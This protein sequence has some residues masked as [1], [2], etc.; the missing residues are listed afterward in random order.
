MRILSTFCLFIV[1]LSA[2]AAQVTFQQ[3]PGL[4]FFDDQGY[5]NGVSWVDVDNDDDLDVCVTGS[6][7]TFPNFT[8]I[9]AIFLNN[10][11]E[12]FTNTGLLN[13]VQKNA[14]R[15]G[16]ADYD[17]DDDLDLYIGATWNSNGINELWNNNGG[18]SLTLT[19]N[20]GATPNVAQPYEG[21]VSWADYDNDGWADL[22]VP[23]WNDLKNKLYRNNGNGSF[24]EITTGAMVNDLGWTSGGFWGDFDN[25]RDLDLFVVNYQIGP[26][27]PG[28]NHLF[29]NNGN[30]TFTKMTNAGPAVTIAQ[31]GRSANWVDANNDGLLDLFVCNQF[32]QD[33]LHINAGNGT[34][35]T[36]FIGATNHTSWSSNWGD[37]DNDGD[38]DLITIGFWN[39]D[40][41]F[42]ENDGFGNLTDVTDAHPNIFPT[43]TSGSN[44]N[45]IV[46]VDYNRDGWLDLH[47]IQ[48]DMAPD[49]FYENETTACRSWIEIKC[50]GMES[51]HAAI[52]TTVRAKSL[53]NGQP[54][55]QMRQ[56]SAQ[57]AATGTN[58]MLL[59]F[60]FDDAAVIDSLIVEWP[61][62]QTCFFTQVSVNQIIDIKE[63][64]SIRVTKTA[65][66]LPGTFQTST[67]CL[68]SLDTIALQPSSS[69]AGI[70][71]SD[72]GNC[73]DG[74]G[75]FSL[76]ELSAGTYLARFISGTLC[77]GFVDSFQIVL[78][79]PLTISA[80]ADTSIHAGE[81]L[82]LNVT[83]GDSYL[84]QPAG[85][86]SCESCP[87]PI[88]TAD[89]STLFIVQGQNM[90]QSCFA[91]DSVFV[92]VLPEP[93]FDWPNAFSPNGDGVNDVFGP[94]FKGEIFAE[95]HLRI[96]ARWGEKV[97]DSILK[98]W[99]GNLSGLPAPS[100]VYI[101]VFD[102]Q[103]VNGESGQ[104]KGSVTLLR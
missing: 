14:F 50:L 25:D 16:W 61:S 36:K 103:M 65:S 77:D 29:R 86:L 4:A 20:S 62:G 87:N 85:S 98:G 93:R 24:S 79:P 39:T 73:V 78:A 8:N 30:G 3:I 90:G 80:S 83:G 76:N 19:P 92:T 64:C 74:M 11:N 13:S 35:T 101:Y 59:H 43:Q 95:Y 6:G 102:Y 34:F 54:W 37:Y 47:I 51:N 104:D 32:G 55:W 9:S 48:P 91:T 81:L 15:H 88:F 56:V 100:D 60:G 58:P 42:W 66:A 10:G 23:R 75:N 57:T 96:Y 45:G 28:T 22:F 84:W 27:N 69:A 41:R 44:S 67:V 2:P 89:T 99:D 71:V 68:P 63:D 72:C 18:T 21:T 7:G 5:L 97:Y 53:R 38:Q 17:N 12:T 1:F 33:L 52:G 49:R 46:W 26:T 70:W 82:N 40:S 94:A 31:N